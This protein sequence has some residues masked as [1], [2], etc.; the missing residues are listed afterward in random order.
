LTLTE[1]LAIML[2]SGALAATEGV[3][4][5]LLFT[6]YVAK[7]LGVEPSQVRAM[8]AATDGDPETTAEEE[9]SAG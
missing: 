4:I 7:K 5:S 9:E 8:D 3:R 2:L 1:L 6:A